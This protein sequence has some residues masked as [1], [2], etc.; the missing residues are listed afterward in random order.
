MGTALLKTLSQRRTC[1][2]CD[3]VGRARAPTAYFRGVLTCLC[4]RS[5]GLLRRERRWTL[6][7]AFTSAN[8]KVVDIT[9]SASGFQVD[10]A[11]LGGTTPG[12]TMNGPALEKKPKVFSMLCI[13]ITHTNWRPKISIPH[14]KFSMSKDTN[15]STG[16]ILI[17]LK[18][19]MR[20]ILIL[21]C[22][23]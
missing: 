13:L 14:T 5:T 9:S 2:A 10:V 18:C 6:Y 7:M 19:S 11:T 8:G 17:T 15:F 3:I 16:S 22:A 1:I 23:I 20:S 4:D 12:A 21:V